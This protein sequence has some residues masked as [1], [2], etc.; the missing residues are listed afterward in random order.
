MK[1]CIIHV[2]NALC[3]QHEVCWT[4]MMLASVAHCYQHLGTTCCMRWKGGGALCF[5]ELIILTYQM[6][7]HHKVN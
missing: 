7:R 3:T 4:D 1:I 6:T 2:R 5:S